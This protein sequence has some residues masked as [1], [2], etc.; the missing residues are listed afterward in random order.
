M[1][2]PQV[3]GASPPK[4]KLCGKRHWKICPQSFDPKGYLDRV[5]KNESHRRIMVRHGLETDQMA[6]VLDKD[7]KPKRRKKK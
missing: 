7:V 2:D 5:P 1:A 6:E 3:S 4:C